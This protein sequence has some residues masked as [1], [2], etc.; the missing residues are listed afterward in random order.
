[1][2]ILSIVSILF[3]AILTACSPDDA[4]AQGGDFIAKDITLAEFNEMDLAQYHLIDVRTPEEF[5]EGHVAGSVNIDWYDDNFV[6]LM[7]E[8]SKDKATIIYCRSG[9]RSK[10]AMKKISGENFPELYNVL[11]GYLRYSESQH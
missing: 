6:T 5:Q 8:L 11:G 1:M 7:A 2:R 10:S 3:L 9:G 4:Q